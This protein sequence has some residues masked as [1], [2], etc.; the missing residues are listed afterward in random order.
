MAGDDKTEQPTHRKLTEA[1][2]KGQVA[3]SM[4]LTTVFMLLVAM[5]MLRNGGA[6]IYTSLSRTVSYY[7][8]SFHEMVFTPAS[9]MPLFTQIVYQVFMLSAIVAVPTYITVI[10]LNLAQVG[11][12]FTSES[13]KP[14]LD[15]LNPLSGFKRIFSKQ[16]F[17]M[18]LKSS[19]EI[20]VVAF[21]LYT[22]MRDQWQVVFRFTDMELRSALFTLA[23]LAYRFS[24]KIIIV[25][26][27]IALLDYIYQ[28]WQFT[29]NLKMTKQEVKDEMK[30]TEGDPMIRSRIRQR[31]REMARKRMMA[32][33]PEAHVVVTNPVHLACAL[34]YDDET[35]AAPVLVAKGQGLIA[36]K[37]REVA[38]SNDIPIVENK[39]LA[40]DIFETIELDQEIPPRLYE[41]VAEIVAFL[42]NLKKKGTA[43]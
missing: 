12:L 7:L 1:R 28:R 40:R 13:I 23:D 5:V 20:G 4:E 6:Y 36:E 17:A 32:A 39:P 31:Q 30:Q 19:I 26:L 10:A 16:G 43:R 35:M 33:V 27:I 41:A 38:K 25:L 42:Y 8:G 3:K 37:I 15:R 34:K 29:E 2:K 9:V 14:Q 21:I 11:F 24:I 22:T 18:L